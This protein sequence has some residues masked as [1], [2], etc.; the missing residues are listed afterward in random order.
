MLYISLNDQ[1][2]FD[3]KDAQKLSCRHK[4]E[5]ARLILQCEPNGQTQLLNKFDDLSSGT[6]LAHFGNR[7]L[8][9]FFKM[10]EFKKSKC[11]TCDLGEQNLCVH[12]YLCVE[13][14]LEWCA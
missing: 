13:N 14:Q 8:E 3:V 10:G 9:M 7:R 12:S 11:N 6:I 1:K 4:F 2:L 5:T